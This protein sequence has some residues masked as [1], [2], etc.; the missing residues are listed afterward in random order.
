MKRPCVYIL[1]S[2]PLGTLYVGVTSDLHKRMAE[3]AQG[4]IQGFTRKYGVKQL[5]YYEYHES[6][7][8]AIQRE[9]QLKDWQRIWKIRLIEAMNPEWH[10]LFDPLSGEIHFGSADVESAEQILSVSGLRP[11]PE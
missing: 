6:M 10:N 11:S 9:R 2:R 5:V 3:H 7:P 4:L 1:A 8:E